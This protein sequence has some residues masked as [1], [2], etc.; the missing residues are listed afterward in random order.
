MSHSQLWQEL[1]SAAQNSTDI[2]HVNV[3]SLTF[4][5]LPRDI[6]EPV[7][8]FLLRVI[9][10]G[11]ISGDEIVRRTKDGIV[12]AALLPG[13][14]QKARRF[15]TENVVITALCH[16]VKEGKLDCIQRME[17]SWS[18]CGWNPHFRRAA[19]VSPL[20][21]TLPK[22]SES[23]AHKRSRCMKISKPW[24]QLNLYPIS[25]SLLDNE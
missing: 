25:G 22:T 14:I 15:C 8:D 13:P 23:P 16:M 17:P 1:R 10:T 11:T 12:D 5:T 7:K 21:Q 4:E 19:T 24:K 9:E 20:P 6:Q 2:N 3:D 18:T